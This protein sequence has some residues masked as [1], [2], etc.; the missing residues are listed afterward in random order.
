MNTCNIANF[1]LGS[2]VV[3][4]TVFSICLKSIDKDIAIL[5]VD[6]YLINSLIPEIL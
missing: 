2:F 4:K 1:Q 6:F 3:K 5:K